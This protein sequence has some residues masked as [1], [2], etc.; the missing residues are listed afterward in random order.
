MDFWKVILT[1]LGSVTMLF[2][3]CKLI[4]NKQVSQMSMFDYINGI[5][6]GSIAAE[7]ATM[8]EKEFY[9][10]LMG[11]V[12]YGMVT[13]AINIWSQKSLKVR[14]FFDGRSYLLFCGGKI[15]RKNFKRAHI[16]LD[17]FLLE[18]RLQGYFDLEDIYAVMS[19]PNG[20]ISILPK[21]S[22]APVTKQDMQVPLDKDCIPAIL[23]KDGAV[24]QENLHGNGKDMQWL[25]NQLKAQHTKAGDV[26]LAYC[27]ADNKLRIY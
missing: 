14:K 11:M 2:I 23:I 6:I 4:G 5:T 16:N 1:S 10:P 27:G 26:F 22:A 17:E 15:D 9:R 19:E 8:P 3:I 20:K 24:I 25:E 7:L 13:Y 18:C 21:E 12:I